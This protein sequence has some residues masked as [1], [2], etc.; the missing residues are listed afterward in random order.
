M[1]LDQRWLFCAMT[2]PQ[3][4]LY[5][6]DPQN[7]WPPTCGTQLAVT[8]N[9]AQPGWE[10]LNPKSLAILYSKITIKITPHF[11][12][13]NLPVTMAWALDKNPSSTLSHSKATAH[14][15]KLLHPEEKCQQAHA[16]ATQ[17]MQCIGH[18][19]KLPIFARQHDPSIHHHHHPQLPQTVLHHNEREIQ[20]AQHHQLI[21]WCIIV[22][23][24][25]ACL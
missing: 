23:S 5:C 22:N 8:F 18:H 11:A 19:A 21:M 24:V 13:Q 1:A 12:L 3:W 20:L 17:K 6:H 2:I 14:A 25:T 7:G 10:Q 15:I 9:I 16:A 4:P